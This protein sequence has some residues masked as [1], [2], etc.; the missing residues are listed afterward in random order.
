MI[1]AFK[2]S[3]VLLLFVV[4]ALGYWI[5]NIPIRGA[6]LGVA[7][8]LFVGLAIGALDPALTMPNIVIVLGL[9]MFV[10]TVGLQSG[11]SFFASFKTHGL[12]YFSFITVALALSMLI[13]IGLHYLMEL[14]AATSAGLLAGSSTNTA[15]LAG[16]LDLIQLSQPLEE[17]E[18]MSN[19]AVVGYSLSYPMGVLGVIFAIALMRRWLKIDYQTEARQL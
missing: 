12:R 3:P 19:A 18:A 16:L 5:G 11:P 4:S 7:A 6:K 14:D 17:Q 2:S 9:S 15:S 1:E 8:V 13:T 10:Y